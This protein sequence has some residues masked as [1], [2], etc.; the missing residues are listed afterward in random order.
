MALDARRVSVSCGY[1]RLETRAGVCGRIDVVRAWCCVMIRIPYPICHQPLVTQMAA[2]TTVH[3]NAT[4]GLLT[5]RV[6]LKRYDISK[7][8]CEKVRARG[9]HVAME[10][11][12]LYPV[13]VRAFVCPASCDRT[14][15]GVLR[16]CVHV[17]RWW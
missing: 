17:C 4:P 1:H 3:F 8:Y 7:L 13:G 12:W 15:P 2:V 6:E 9:V 14:R 5:S 11:R 16:R 10:V